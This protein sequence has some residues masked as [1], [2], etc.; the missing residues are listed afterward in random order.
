MSHV[1]KIVLDIKDL[2]ALATAG[3]AR[4][5]IYDPA[6]TTYAWWGYSV[7][8]YPLPEGFTAA[9]L[10]KCDA[11]V[12]RVKDAAEGDFEIGVCRRKDGK[13]GYE[14]LFDFFGHRAQGLLKALGDQTGKALKQEYAAAV[15]SKMYAKNGYKVQRKDQ[16]GRIVLTATK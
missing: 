12:L 3:A 14:L 15:A 1:C 5:L 6:A 8:D 13:P 11:G 16:N 10:G 2:A 4:G 9:D 7:G